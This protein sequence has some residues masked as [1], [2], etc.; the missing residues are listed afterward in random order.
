MGQLEPFILQERTQIER[1]TLENNLGLV[2]TPYE[3]TTPFLD[4]YPKEILTYVQG[5]VCTRMFIAILCM[6][7]KTRNNANDQLHKVGTYI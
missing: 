6:P 5:E 1:N 7:I 2:C 3:A 4:K